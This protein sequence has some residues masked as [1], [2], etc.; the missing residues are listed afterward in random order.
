MRKFLT[1]LGIILTFATSAL[2]E[3]RHEV[4][5]PPDSKGREL[6][7]SVIKSARQ[8]VRVAAYSFTSA[9]VAEALGEAHKRGVD[10]Q[11][12]A[13]LGKG[14]HKLHA[15]A[16]LA[17]QG[18]PVRLNGNYRTMHNKFLVVDG[19]HVQTGSLNYNRHADTDSNADNVLVIWDAPGLASQ[20][21]A[22]WERLW[23][24]GEDVK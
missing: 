24:E 19:K 16:P 9:L 14:D 5:F 2:A 17:R 8:S 18:V 21:T 7:L 6:V 11:I 4:A 23:N 10:V 22:E 15:A 20:Y 3:G 1:A 12:V 13:D